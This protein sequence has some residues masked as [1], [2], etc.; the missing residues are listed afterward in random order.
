[1]LVIKYLAESQVKSPAYTIKK[2]W[3]PASAGMM[4]LEKL[5]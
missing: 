1:M 2:A 5:E 4:P 3:I